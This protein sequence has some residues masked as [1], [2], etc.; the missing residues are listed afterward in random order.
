MADC[1]HREGKK[2][3]REMAT[4]E[5][6]DVYVD[7]FLWSVD[8]CCRPSNPCATSTP[9]HVYGARLLG[10]HDPKQRRAPTMLSMFRKGSPRCTCGH[11]QPMHI[12]P[13]GRL[14]P[15]IVIAGA[16]NRNAACTVALPP[17]T[18]LGPM[19]CF[20]ASANVCSPRHLLCCVSIRLVCGRVQ[21]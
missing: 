11:G 17:R 12:L 4:A 7:D 19:L 20:V 3:V 1:R 2:W 9:M 15:R 18:V 21:T 6:T 13:R 5:M 10:S 14:A 8:V 16:H